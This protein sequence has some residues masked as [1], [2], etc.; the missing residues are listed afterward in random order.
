[1][2]QTLFSLMIVPLLLPAARG[3]SAATPVPNLR[4]PEVAPDG[5]ITFRLFAPN[6]RQ[7]QVLYFSSQPLRMRK[8]ERGVWIANSD[9]MAP[10]FYPYAFNVDGVTF[11]D[12]GNPLTETFI[13]GTTVSFVRVPGPSSLPWEMNDVPHGNITRHFYHSAV[14]GDDRD[15]YVYTPPM[16]DPTAKTQY[17]VLYLLH[18]AGGTA[19]EWMNQ[20]RANIILDNLIAQRKA[21]PM[22]I[23]T[24]LGY[25]SSAAN[26]STLIEDGILKGFDKLTDSVLNEVTPIVEKIYR[27]ARNPEARAIA[28]YS[29]GGAQSLYIGLRHPEKFAYVAGMSSA[30]VSLPGPG[31][32]RP[33]LPTGDTWPP[34]DS[35]WFPTVF[36]ALDVKSAGQFKLLWVSCGMEDRLIGHNRQFRDWLQSKG[37]SPR[38]VETSG[39]H[40]MMVWRRNLAELATLLFKA[41]EADRKR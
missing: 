23:V 14:I 26:V 10:D 34:L 41:N 18:E 28:G 36:P 25:G 24:P 20:G 2:I 12:P 30:L 32:G 31:G 35:N 17:P 9:R 11:P 16:Y 1:M 6:A 22:I 39:S 27:A 13:T 21:Q 38:Y 5:S 40:T 4:S 8:D 33:P 3:Q 37:V 19:G 15:F 7:V 29:S